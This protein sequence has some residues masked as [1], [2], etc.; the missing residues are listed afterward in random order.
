MTIRNT[1][2]YN[3]KVHGDYEKN[4]KPSM[5][6]P[7]MTYTPQELLIRYAKGLPMDKLS[8]HYYHGDTE[9]PDLRRMDLTEVDDLAYQ[10]KQQ[11]ESAKIAYNKKVQERQEI[12]KKDLEKQRADLMADIQKMAAKP[13]SPAL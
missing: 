9:L 2:T 1:Y 8:D 5:T 11:L 7:D 4:G 10:A 12:R 3:Y 6:Q 13:G